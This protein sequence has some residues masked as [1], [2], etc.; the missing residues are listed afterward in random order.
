ML[1]IGIRNAECLDLS[2]THSA[3]CAP[4]WRISANWGKMVTAFL[5]ASMK[6]QTMISDSIFN[7]FLNCKLKSYLIAT[8]TT[9]IVGDTSHHQQHLSNAFITT[10]IERIRKHIPAHETFE[11]M[12]SLEVLQQ[13]RYRLIINPVITAPG[14]HNQMHALGNLSECRA[15]RRELLR[16]IRFVA[17]AKLSKS[18]R[19]AGS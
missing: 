15:S 4:K 10:G 8:S 6:P 13:H 3:F 14:I 7:A 1:N 11:G 19:I 12:P 16:P 17:S 18:R 9:C 2:D 5:E